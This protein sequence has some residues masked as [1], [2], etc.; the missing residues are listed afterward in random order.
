MITAIDL[1]SQYLLDPLNH[2]HESKNIALIVTIVLG[3]LTLGMA[4]GASA[5]WQL[6]RPIEE[7]NETH[8]KINDLFKKFFTSDKSEERIP[9]PTTKIFESNQEP[10]TLANNIQPTANSPDVSPFVQVGGFGQGGNTCFIAACLQIIRHIPKLRDRLNP[11]YQL[12]KIEKENEEHFNMRL[13]IRKKI[14]KMLKATDQ[15]ETLDGSVIRKLHQMLYNYNKN[16]I[17]HPGD[18]GDVS[19][20]I[21]TIT[22]ILDVYNANL[23]NCKDL[24]DEL[25]DDNNW[26][27]RIADVINIQH[28]FNHF[29][30]I[31][32]D[33]EPKLFYECKYPSGKPY[34][35]ILI[36]AI[37]ASN[38]A[39]AYVKDDR[40]PNK[41]TCCND[42]TITSVSEFPTNRRM[43]YFIYKKVN[44]RV[45]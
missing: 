37:T 17:A 33:N 3:I 10:A 21:D 42:G 15:G 28:P 29:E 1:A 5:L 26:H 6:C 44:Q 23:Y 34:K 38:H 45:Q 43:A 41:W 2:K 12:E 8:K 35:V 19:S 25:L 11:E 32:L 27:I 40:Q 16:Q 20:V 14:F 31:K 30:G 22:S 9:S 7:E 18:M 36:G 4:Q 13:K 39:V 24:L